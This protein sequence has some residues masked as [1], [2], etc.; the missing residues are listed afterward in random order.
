MFNVKN[1][2]TFIIIAFFICSSSGWTQTVANPVSAK[3]A[4]KEKVQRQTGKEIKQPQ[5]EMITPEEIKLGIITFE[6]PGQGIFTINKTKAGVIEWSTEGPSGW[7]KSD[8]QKLSGVLKD[9]PQSLGVEVR[10]YHKESSDERKKNK[11]SLGYV[12][13]ELESE[14][15]TLV[16]SREMSAGIHKEAIKIN[17]GNEQKTV[18]VSFIIAYTQ[19]TPLITLSPMRLDMG[20]I[21]PDKAVSKKII[22]SNSGKEKLTWSVA[23]QK[24]E[25][26]SV[27]EN[28]QQGRYISFVNED[29]KESDVYAAPVHLKDIVEFTGKWTGSNGY[30]ACA[31]GENVIKINFSGKGIILYLSSFRKEGNLAL[32]LDKQLINR[33]DLFEDLEASDGELLISDKLVEGPHVLTITSKNNYLVFEGVK[34]LG[35]NT[36]YLPENS[37]KIVP[38]S[39]VTTRQSNYL[40]VTLNRGQMLPGYYVDEIVFTTNG[41]EEFVEVFAEVLPDNISKAIDIYRYFNGEDYL[42]TADPQPEAKRLIQNRYAK[43]G[44][45]FRLFK[46]DTPGTAPF[47]R[48]Y[49][50]QKR[51]HFYHSNYTGGGKNLAGY[52]YEGSIG[53]IATSRLTNTRELYRWYNEKK[54]HY[55]YTTDAQG[56]TINKKEYHFDGIAGY[57]K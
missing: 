30:P 37:I 44:I 28:Y 8:R 22:L 56:G 36:V 11:R 53:N 54:G 10:L 12:E 14:E 50:P 24:H 25:K 2:F 19:K 20:S 6:K 23:L 40:T 41:G 34:I 5:A 57:V 32:S 13:M 21:L 45:A 39:G 43:E 31:D 7:K 3:P 29:I 33:V 4:V 48:W 38:D 49:N 18:F 1:Y 26:E 27:P 35:V 15:G 55:F 51:C 16:C 46:P 9:K 17:Y 47:Y 42:F 52:I